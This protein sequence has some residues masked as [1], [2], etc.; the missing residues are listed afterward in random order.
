MLA[1]P[2]S[3]C[4]TTSTRAVLG[5]LLDSAGDRRMAALG[6]DYSVAVEAASD[7]MS[8]T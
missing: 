5:K 7:Q 1:R 8:P 3:P 6:A 2:V 4:S